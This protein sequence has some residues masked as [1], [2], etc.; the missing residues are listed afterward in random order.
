[1]AHERRHIINAVR[2][3][4]WCKEG[5]KVAIGRTPQINRSMDLAKDTSTAWATSRRTRLYP[6]GWFASHHQVC[7][8]VGADSVQAA[9]P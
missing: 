4:Q 1:M 2:P 6:E 3:W 7:S 8:S 5:L 9:A